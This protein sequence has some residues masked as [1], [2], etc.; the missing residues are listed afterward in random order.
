M[1]DAANALVLLLGAVI[2]ACGGQEESGA[3][4]ERPIVVATTTQ[5][6]DIVRQFAEK[7]QVNP[8]RGLT[9]FRVSAC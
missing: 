6:G 1:P 9:P 2:A 4:T 7:A 3:V 5:L 8:Q